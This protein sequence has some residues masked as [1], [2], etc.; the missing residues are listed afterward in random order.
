MNSHQLAQLPIIFEQLT[1]PRDR[2]GVRFPFSALC[3]LVFLGLLARINEM[4]VLVRWAD[5]HWDQLREPLGFTRPEKPSATCISRALAGLSLAEF[6]RAFAEW[7]QPQLE[8]SERFL[9]A[10]VDGKTCC[11]GFDENGDPEILLNVF[12]HNLKPALSQWQVGKSKTNEPGCLKANLR[13]LL[14]AYPLLNLLTGDAIFLQRPL[15]E[16]MQDNGCHYLFQV[17]A[18]QPE[19]LEALNFCFDADRIGPATGE[20]VD[21]KGGMRRCVVFGTIS[22]TPVG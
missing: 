1:D 21:K 5:A 22:L 7:I 10:A 18:N 4:A 16:V 14:H 6:R 15:L 11:Q 12:L 2:R 20:T 9:V 19:T 3:S 13:E 17:K 8:Q